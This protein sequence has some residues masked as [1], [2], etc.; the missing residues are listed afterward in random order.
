V[1][2][3]DGLSRQGGERGAGGVLRDAVAV[4]AL[5]SVNIPQILGYTRIAGTQ[6]V[7]GLYTG[8]TQPSNKP[9]SVGPLQRDVDLEK[10]PIQQVLTPLAAGARH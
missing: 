10:L 1:R 7:A 2:L 3:F 5:A 6:V 4:I 9:T 8:L